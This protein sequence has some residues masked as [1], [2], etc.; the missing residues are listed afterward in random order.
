MATNLHDA[1]FKDVYSNPRYGLDIFRLAFTPSEFDLFNWRTLRSEMTTFVTRDLKERRTDLVFSVKLKGRRAEAR[2]L[3][4]LEHKS[5]DDAGVLMQML[6]Y[7]CEMYRKWERKCPVIPILVAH[8]R[9]RWRRT[10]RFQDSLKGFP[11]A[12]RRKFGRNVLD[13]T[14]KMLDLSDVP[15]SKTS[16]LTSY[17]ILFTLRS[18]WKLDEKKVR[19]LFIIGRNLP[20]EDRRILMEKAVEYIREY[21]KSFTWKELTRIEEEVTEEKERIMPP[22]TMTLEKEREKGL[23]KGRREGRREGRME[24]QRESALSMLRDGLDIRKIAAYTGLPEREVGK[25]RQE[26]KK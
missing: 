22:L 1:V 10:V 17:P 19:G 16:R 14:C 20:P 3:F 26:A 12:L 6:E 11:D 13:F 9:G 18:V 24:T 23:K 15:E 25:L 4:L 2:I 7:Q 8:G 21:D 5:R